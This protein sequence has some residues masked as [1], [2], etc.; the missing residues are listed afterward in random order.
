MLY[1]EI[2]SGRT[3]GYATVYSTKNNT[4][5]LDR[6]RCTVRAPKEALKTL[7]LGAERPHLQ[8]FGAPRDRALGMLPSHVTFKTPIEREIW[9]RTNVPK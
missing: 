3:E 4:I 6:F 1:V 8:L 7:A 5:E 9:E 2:G